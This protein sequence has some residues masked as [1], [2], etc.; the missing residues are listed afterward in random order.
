MNEYHEAI[1]DYAG[2]LA[3]IVKG[4]KFHDSH[5][6]YRVAGALEVLMSL[7]GLFEIGKPFDYLRG[8]K[9]Y[10]PLIGDFTWVESYPH[11]ILRKANEYLNEIQ[12]NE[13]N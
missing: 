2:R 6:S 8:G 12:A 13:Q 3:G 9:K 7:Q 1:K 5:H 11:F 10:V 4:N